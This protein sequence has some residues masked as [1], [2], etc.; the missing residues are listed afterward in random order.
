[1]KRCVVTGG[2][3]HLGRVLT[4]TLADQGSEVVAFWGP[5]GFG[6]I[7]S[8]KGVETVRES[9]SKPEILREILKNCGTLFHLQSAMQTDV[10]PFP[11]EKERLGAL[12]QSAKQAGVQKIVFLGGIASVGLSDDALDHRAEKEWAVNPSSDWFKTDLWLEKTAHCMVEGLGLDFRVGL[13]GFMMGP[14]CGPGSKTVPLL[15]EFLEWGLA[16][17]PRGGFNLADVRDVAVGMVLIDRNGEPGNR[18]FLGGD[19][20]TYRRM[21]EIV[22][23]RCGVEKM[24]DT[25]SPEPKEAFAQLSSFRKGRSEPGLLYDEKTV[26]DLYG[27]FA[28]IKGTK[29]K[30]ALKYSYRTKEDVIVDTVRW[31]TENNRLSGTR[32]DSIRIKEKPKVMPIHF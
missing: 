12:L 11:A 32:K 15:Q 18:Y 3:S 23:E 14:D 24:D 28:Y 25:L 1:M 29:A 21:Y 26:S 5:G 19:N 13:A 6:E 17:N 8:H 30:H 9:W 4:R 10:E 2:E 16:G 27:R 20:I 7:F 22:S 31:L